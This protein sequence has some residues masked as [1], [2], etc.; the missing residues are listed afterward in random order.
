M[1][2]LE[3]RSKDKVENTSEDKPEW[4]SKICLVCRLSFDR[5]TMIVKKDK[6]YCYPCYNKNIKSNRTR[7]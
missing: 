4:L 1:K 6:W 3:N 2:E 5:F 7:K